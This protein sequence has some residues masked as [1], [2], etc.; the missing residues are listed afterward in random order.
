L[1]RRTQRRTL[2]LLDANV[3]INVAQGE[4]EGQR[5]PVLDKLIGQHTL[6]CAKALL[7]HYSGA[8]YK[9]LGESAIRYVDSVVEVVRTEDMPEREFS[10][11]RIHL[12]ARHRPG[13]RAD[14][15]LVRI[16][17]AAMNRGQ[18]SVIVVSNDDHIYNL[19]AVLRTDFGIRAVD[20]QGYLT[21]FCPSKD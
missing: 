21:Q 19:D 7:N 14:V 4:V 9:R 1:P 13:H 15:F 3:F 12:N 18:N 16:A 17:V 2:V 8:I 10:S 11:R 5:N 6:I 20:S